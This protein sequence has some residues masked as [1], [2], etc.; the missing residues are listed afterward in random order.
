M[1]VKTLGL[2]KPATPGTPIQVTTDRSIVAH[3]IWVSPQPGV[4]QKT[5][6]GRSTLT[7][8]GDTPELRAIIKVFLPPSVSGFCPTFIIDGKSGNPLVLADYWVDADLAAQGL[9]IAYT[10]I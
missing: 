2:I 6:L 5:Y 3:K 10:E 7:R 1:I 4:T 8:I 9:I